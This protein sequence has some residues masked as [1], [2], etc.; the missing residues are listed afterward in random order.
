MKSHKFFD[1]NQKELVYLNYMSMLFIFLMSILFIFTGCSLFTGNIAGGRDRDTEAKGLFPSFSGSYIEFEDVNGGDTYP[2]EDL[3][4]YVNVINSGNAEARDVRVNLVTD[5]FFKL[6]KENREGIYWNIDSIKAGE[7]VK[8]NTRL[9]L[10]DSI[11]EDTMVS[12]N[13]KINSGKTDSF[14]GTNYSTMVYCVKPFEGNFIPIIGL[15]AIED[16]IEAPI[17]LYTSHFEKLCSVLKEYGYETI[18]FMDLLKYIDFGKA[19]P[20]RPVIITSDDGFQDVYINAFPILKKYG[21][22]MTVFLVTGAVGDTEASRKTNAY[23]NKRTNV[24]RPILT[25]PEINEMHEY[26]CEFLS[27]TVNH[28]RLGLATDGEFLYELERSK[29]DIESHLGGEVLFFAWPYDNNSPSKWHLIPEAGYRGAVRY[30]TGVEDMRTINLYDID[31]I[32]FNSY[33]PPAQYAGYLNLDRSIQIEFRI[34]N[35]DDKYR[36]GKY[37]G[38]T[39]EEFMV[40]YIINNTNTNPVRIRS[41]EL[42]LPENIELAEVG[43]DGYINQY[44]GISSNIYMWVSDSYTIPGNGWINLILKLKG[45]APGEYVINFRITYKDYYINCDG[46]EVEIKSRV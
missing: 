30:G 19:L 37:T 39:G 41:L 35:I 36:S 1:K 6:N 8:L 31:R 2:G 32:E 15:H 33:I 17:E 26:G 38:E 23:F 14:I 10:R 43:Y 11:T 13:L 24:I 18:T 9:T 34:D 42:E 12:C 44:P 5:E 4:V 40:E 22:K 3:I 21:Y 25:W 20:E 28:V 46:L 7:K 45:K 27:H 29:E 16:H